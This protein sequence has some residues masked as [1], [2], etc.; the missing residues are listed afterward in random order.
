LAQSPLV[1]AYLTASSSWYEAL[2]ITASYLLSCRNRQT[3]VPFLTSTTTWSDDQVKCLAYNSQDFNVEAALTS[4]NAV[5]TSG[6]SLTYD[7]NTTKWINST[8]WVPYNHTD[9][10]DWNNGDNTTDW[11]WDEA[12][13]NITNGTIGTLNTHFILSFPYQH[14]FDFEHGCTECGYGSF[15]DGI[16]MLCVAC[17]L[18]SNTSSTTSTSINACWCKAGYFNDTDTCLG[19]PSFNCLTLVCW[20]IGINAISNTNRV[21]SR[22]LL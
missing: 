11:N 17:P 14:F 10:I 21:S 4:T 19:M 16:D 20:L 12:N 7:V 3:I 8:I 6:R 2:K 15:Y 22:L 18:N 13:T 5:L 1:A 9:I